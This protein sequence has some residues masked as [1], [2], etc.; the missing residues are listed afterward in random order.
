MP[1]LLP[2]FYVPPEVVENLGTSA[3]QTFAEA[4]LGIPAIG[5]AAVIELR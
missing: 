3:S 1:S 5:L 2:W 4:D